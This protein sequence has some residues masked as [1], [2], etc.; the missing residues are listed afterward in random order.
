MV[1]SVAAA[2]VAEAVVGN[3]RTLEAI[4]VKKKA[5]VMLAFFICADCFSVFTFP[6]ME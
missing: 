5:G 3:Q 2:V 1:V 6:A 4:R